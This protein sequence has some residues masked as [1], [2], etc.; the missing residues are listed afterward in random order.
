MLFGFSRVLLAVSHALRSSR[1]AITGASGA[2]LYK[3]I[4]TGNP[5][6]DLFGFSIG[7]AGDVNGD[8]V[9]DVVIG[10][11][12]EK[13]ES[14]CSVSFAQYGRATILSPVCPA[15]ERYCTA[16]TNSLGCVPIIGS[17]GSP[18]LGGPDD[19]FV[20]AGNVLSHERGLLAWSLG[21]AAIP[22]YG[23]TLCLA[24]PIVREL[25]AEIVLA[26][27]ALL[28]EIAHGA[29]EYELRECIWNLGTRD[30]TSDALTKV[31]EG[32]TSFDEAIKMCWV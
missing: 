4:S 5:D 23:G 8:G 18:S 12:G 9:P 1:Q 25:V 21:A 16:K 29:A 31:C 24:L 30:L 10:A 11:I 26:D 19:F 20:R 2:L 32:I 14:G 17:S 6:C 28:Q 7:G 3:A 27:E 13:P 15:P 22:F